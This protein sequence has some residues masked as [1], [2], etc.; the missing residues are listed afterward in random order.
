MMALEVW[1]AQLQE[2]HQVIDY[3]PGSSV[4]SF[5]QKYFLEIK[6]IELSTT[7]KLESEV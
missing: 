6:G 3:E 7:R 2:D 1:S 4:V 5:I